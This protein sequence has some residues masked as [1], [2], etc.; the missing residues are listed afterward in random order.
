MPWSGE[1]LEE[2]RAQ[3]LMSLP[4]FVFG[5]ADSQGRP[6]VTLV[7]SPCLSV[8]PDQPNTLILDRRA[9]VP[10][11]AA[12]MTN[13]VTWAGLGIDYSRRKRLKVAGKINLVEKSSSVFLRIS[14]V[15]GN[16]PKYINTRV[17]TF[18]DR[19]SAIG[20]QQT[21]SITSFRKQVELDSRCI[22][23]IHE[24]D[25]F[26]VSSVY[27]DISNR[28]LSTMDTNHRGGP[29]GFVRASKTQIFWPDYSGNRIYSTLGNIRESKV[30]GL[31]FF[32]FIT[33]DILHITGTASVVIPGTS[34]LKNCF[35]PAIV[36]NVTDWQYLPHGL[37]LIAD[38]VVS[39]SP[40]NP[41]V[42]YTVDESSSAS[43]SK[44]SPFTSS[45]VEIVRVDEL[46]PTMSTFT[47]KIN[48]PISSTPG[49]GFLFPFFFFF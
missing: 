10:E 27:N 6:F 4:F 18:L 40:Y 31:V 17:V 19:S 20:Q 46:T 5:F 24:S 25:T 36:L 44:A 26:F 9:V 30:A 37:N 33:G 29:K 41:L 43:L 45:P 12:M 32:S 21:T 11:M 22:S 35:G 3:F 2:P 42:K 47:F 1:V 49:Y 28:S 15:M 38:D 16:C 14:E 23:L 48:H 39:Y 8:T 34:V 13:G 7:P